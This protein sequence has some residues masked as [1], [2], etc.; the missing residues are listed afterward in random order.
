MRELLRDLHLALRGFRRRPA[1]ALSAGLTLAAG[2]A[3][4]AAAFALIYSTLLLPLPYDEPD[5]LAVVMR[6]EADIDARLPVAPAPFYDWVEQNRSFN[7]MAAAEVREATLSGDGPAEAVPGL[8]VS[9]NLFDLLGRPMAHGRGFLPGEDAETAEDVVVISH[10]LWQR[11]FGGDSGIVGRRIRLNDQ[12]FTVVGVTAPD[13]RFP[14]FWATGAELWTPLKF[15]PEQASSRRASSLR[16]FARL[17]PGVDFTE[18][19]ADM[20]AIAARLASQYPEAHAGEGVSVESLAEVATGDARPALLLLGGATGLLLVIACLNV[21]NLLLARASQRRAETAV[22]MALGAPRRAVLRQ[23]LA[24]STI[25]A[26]IG[27]VV[28]LAGAG[29]LIALVREAAPRGAEALL[30]RLEALSFGGPAVA[31]GAAVTVA[32]A[33]LCGLVPALRLSSRDVQSALSSGGGTRGG[34][35]VERRQR[36]LAAGEIAVGML[37]ASAAGLLLDSLWR[38]ESIDPG[39]RSER[40]LTLQVPTRRAEYQEPG[41]KA[42]FFDA[43]VERVRALPGVEAASLV[44]HIPLGGDVWGLPFEVEGAPPPEPGRTPSAVYRVIDPSYLE[45]MRIPLIAGR[46]LEPFDNSGSEPVALVNQTLAERRWPSQSAIGK[47]IRVGSDPGEDWRRVVGVVAD[48]R[49]GDWSGQIDEEV[50]LP[51]R[52]NAFFRDNPRFAM[53]LAV[54]TQGDPAALTSAVVAQVRQLDPETPVTAVATMQ[55]V[56]REA[57]W[58]PRWLTATL[59]FLAAGALGLAAVG[60]FGVTS[61]AV[62]RRTRELGLRAA[63]GA[64]RSDLMRLVLGQSVALAGIGVAVGLAAALGLARLLRG[65]LYETAPL[66]PKALL[67]AAL[68]LLVIAAAAAWLPARRAAGVEPLQALRYE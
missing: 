41:R 52:Q 5:Q 64:R 19:A 33:L 47:R 11:R 4:N 54:R 12:A 59:S 24:E 32:A 61:Y 39:F 28:G 7:Q 27:G 53:T 48:V 2:V 22:R 38:L 30:P 50:Y 23:A 62:V 1:F 16:V 42:A 66:E 63:L 60:V 36:R 45:V 18:A 34:T 67:G 58:R 26:T 56:V 3:V 65:L 46:D 20:E 9:P 29:W 8:R 57:L 10:G 14:P 68:L 49:Q 40:V 25:I 21:A 43:L 37:L 51:F 17:K 55:Q 31:W 15:S 35:A 44:N 13:F 6:R